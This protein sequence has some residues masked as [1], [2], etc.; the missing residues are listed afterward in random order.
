MIKNSHINNLNK[1]M[2]F[3]EKIKKASLKQLSKAQ[4]KNYSRTLNLFGVK[5]YYD[6]INGTPIEEQYFPTLIDLE[7]D[8][9][10]T[11]SFKE[12]IAR[13]ERLANVGKLEEEVEKI[14]DLIAIYEKNGKARK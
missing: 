5:S 8:P 1:G 11:Q 2:A 13:G 4:E 10:T 6:T 12:G 3:E 14:N 7:V 9:R